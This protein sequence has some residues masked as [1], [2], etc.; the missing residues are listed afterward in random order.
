MDFMCITV[1][2]NGYAQNCVLFSAELRQGQ[3]NLA[4]AD[5]NSIVMSF[6]NKSIQ[7]S[8][9]FSTMNETVYAIWN[10]TAG[11]NSL[12]SY[13]GYGQGNFY[14]SETPSSVFDNISNSSYS[15]YGVCNYSTWD[16]SCGKNTGFYITFKNGPYLLRAFRICAGHFRAARDPLT[17]TI[18]GSNLAGAALT[19]GTSWTLIYNGS[20]GLTTVPGRSMCGELQTTENSL[21][22]SSYR[23]LV[24]AKRS[25]DTCVEYSEVNF[26]T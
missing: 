7:A 8:T 10:T 23:L 11:S 19:L 9:V 5:T 12:A 1:Y 17:I 22:F 4:T 21:W 25:V 3:L 24:T 6:K 14:P 2:Y 18:E 16:L 26:L 20:T 15:S 13:S